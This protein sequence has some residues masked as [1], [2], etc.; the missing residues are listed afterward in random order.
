MGSGAA[1]TPTVA[2]P[3]RAG[4]KPSALTSD[5]TNR[6]VYVTDFASNHLI[7]YTVQSSGTLN[8]ML[9]GPFRTGSEPSAIAVDPR[10]R[11]LYISNSLDESV[12]A[13]VIDLASGTPSSAV[14][15]TGASINSTDTE[16]VSIVVDP[17]LGRYVY[18]ANFLGNTISGF[19]IDP[20]AGSLQP[21]QATPFP[22]TQP[23]PTAIVCVPHGN[24]ATQSVA[25]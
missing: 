11:F 24:H 17:A 2:S 10:G 14:N 18:T 3:Y 6:F 16:P 21:A 15:V 13:Y 23:K 1:L 5:P 20:N 19:R 8:F 7:G 4:I 12:S 22:T 25:P 9:N